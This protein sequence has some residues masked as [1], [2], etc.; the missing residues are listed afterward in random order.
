LVLTRT[1]RHKAGLDAWLLRVPA[2][3]PCLQALA[4]GRFALA[5]R[6][7]LDSD[8]PIAEALRLGMLAT[9][10]AAYAAR[11]DA[12]L[13]A[14]EEGEPLTEAL[15]R[16]RIFPQDFL[17]MVAV[18]EEGGRVPEVLRHQAEHY[19]DEA[20]RRLGVLVR[21][22]TTCVWLAYATFT[23]IAIFT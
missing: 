1:L 2:L 19:H 21:T 9:G 4:L 20:G 5:A 8:L 18:G 11:T 13:A 7:T 22:A 17:N 16:A 15:S 3:G 14:L 12:V 10:N 23:I 6:M